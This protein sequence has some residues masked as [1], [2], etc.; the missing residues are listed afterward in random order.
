MKWR[1][2]W[3]IIGCISSI[4]LGSCEI[5]NPDEDIPA[6]VHIDS[7]DLQLK[8]P[9]QE[10][11]ASERITDAWIFLDDDLIGVF[12]LPADIPI[13]HKGKGTL[14]VGAGIQNNGISATRIRYPFFEVYEDPEFDFQPGEVVTLN[15]TVS[16]FANLDFVWDE[17]FEDIAVA[18]DSFGE[19]NVQMVREQD[20]LLILPT[21]DNDPNNNKAS[22]IV[23]LNDAAPIF[24]A[25]ST[26]RLVLP[27]E[28]TQIFLEMDYKAS[29]RLL[30]GLRTN[31]TIFGLINTPLIDLNPTED[32]NGNLKW[33]K[34]YIH[35]TPYVSTETSATDFR[36]WFKAV[37]DASNVESVIML[38]NLKIVHP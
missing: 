29:T 32:E 26:P 3:P 14:K 22:G 4:V 38:D 1:S 34:I 18:L 15:P 12:E 23:R 19:S 20:P 30:V 10:G 7:I 8:N 5:I 35:L 16:Y 17:N 6:Y 21:P 31:T 36:L 25:A 28:G 33:N 27:Q 11:A 24:E 37:H 13:L 9:N 2:I